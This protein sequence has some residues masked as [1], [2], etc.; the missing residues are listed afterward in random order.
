MPIPVGIRKKRVKV[1]SLVALV[2]KKRKILVQVKDTG[3]PFDK[4]KSSKVSD[5]RK[6]NIEDVPWNAVKVKG[7]YVRSIRQIAPTAASKAKLK[8]MS[9]AQRRVRRRRLNA[10]LFKRIASDNPG[11][12]K[13]IGTRV[14]YYSAK[15][16]KRIKE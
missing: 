4:T 15:T 16:G 10:K 3:K 9:V 13:N 1:I 5:Q 7:S 2:S 12:F 14:G 6:G 8:N 11:N